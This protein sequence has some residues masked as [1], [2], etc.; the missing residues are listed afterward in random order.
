MK[1][2]CFCVRSWATPGAVVSNVV[3]L[4]HRNSLRVTLSMPSATCGTYESSMAMVSS[5]S[6]FEP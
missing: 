5:V 2:L 1:A 6:G 3:E 4:V